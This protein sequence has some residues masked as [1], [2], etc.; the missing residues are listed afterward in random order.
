MVKGSDVRAPVFALMAMLGALIFT[1]FTVYV[2]FIMAFSV[3]DFY[4]GVEYMGYF[5]SFAFILTLAI[6]AVFYY[7]AV[8]RRVG[9]WKETR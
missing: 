3:T 4:I 2:L 5:F 6:S 8:E 1:V 9:A 7:F